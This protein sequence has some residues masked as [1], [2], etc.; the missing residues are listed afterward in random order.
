MYKTSTQSN[1]YCKTIVQKVWEEKKTI[2]CRVSYSDT[3]H[4]VGF[5]ECYTLTLGI[6]V[7]LP[8]VNGWH[9]AKMITEVTVLPQT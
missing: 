1:R 3:R 6:Y 5:A 9:S 4:I 2:V 8:C 7:G